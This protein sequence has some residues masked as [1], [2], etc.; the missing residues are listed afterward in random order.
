MTKK[1]DSVRNI[2][3]LCL[4]RKF[5]CTSIF[6]LTCKFSVTHLSEYSV[7]VCGTMLSIPIVENDIEIY[8]P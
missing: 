1:N 6:L 8:R 7:C 4:G 5:D 3:R 2:K